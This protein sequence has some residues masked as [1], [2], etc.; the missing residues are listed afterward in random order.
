MVFGGERAGLKNKDLLKC[1]HVCRFDVNPAYS[2]LNLSHAVQL[3]VHALRTK[4]SS[5]YN[6]FSEVKF[7]IT[8][9]RNTNNLN[10]RKSG[11]TQKKILDLKKSF[12]ELSSKIGLI[13]QDKQGRI[14]DKISRILVASDLSENDFKLL[15]SFFALIKKK[16]KEK[17]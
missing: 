13:K 12:L 6:V 14:E 4:L 3:V 1:T 8:K 9:S 11:I 7:D 5:Q 15:H 2:S 17:S 16:L 10:F